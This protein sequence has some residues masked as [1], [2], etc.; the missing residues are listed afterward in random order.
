MSD[1]RDRAAALAA[2]TRDAYARDRYSAQS[3]YACCLLL[4]RRGLGEAEA[5]VA[6]RSRWPRAAADWACKA[7][8]ATSRDLERY[9][10]DNRCWGEIAREETR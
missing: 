2:R 7:Y 10:D 1:L 3:W 9:M 8:G 6:L 5:E 4:L